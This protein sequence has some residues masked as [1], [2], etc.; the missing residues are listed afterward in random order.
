V[1]TGGPSRV[2][3]GDGDVQEREYCSTLSETLQQAAVG[4]RFGNPDAFTAWGHSRSGRF[5][6]HKISAASSIRNKYH[7]RSVTVMTE[8]SY[9]EVLDN[10][11]SGT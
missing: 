5:S 8:L 3:W 6:E 2:N 1:V 4:R 9:L 11:T 10:E 7:F